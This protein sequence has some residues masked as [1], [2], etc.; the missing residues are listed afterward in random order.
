VAEAMMLHALGEGSLL[1]PP[2]VAV[3][4]AGAAALYVRGLG[5]TRQ[6]RPRAVAF[7]CGWSL[8]GIALATPLHGAGQ[9]WLSAHMLQHMLL[10]SLAAPLLVWSRPTGILLRGLPDPGRSV[11]IRTMGWLRPALRR[12]SG[13]G[14]A[15]ALQAVLLWLWHAPAFYTRTLTSGLVHDA[16][17]ITLL[18]G[19]VL[20][21][22][23]IEPAFRQRSLAG[24]AVLSLFITTLHTSVLAALL[25]FSSV[26]WYAPYAWSPE[27]L[28][29]QQLAG[30]IM[31]VPGALPYV[32]GALLVLW[33][34]LEE[35]RA[36]IT[37][38]T[39]GSGDGMPSPDAISRVRNA[40]PEA[41]PGRK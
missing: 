15:C 33:A 7:I 21:W 31:W 36:R 29:D 2:G 30:L 11:V 16:Q 25:T 20:F 41:A 26:V 28:S 18:G 19:A 1:P 27:A 38:T 9:S 22:A 6:K 5:R 14:V 3:P 13:I 23:S 35:P 10:M 4:L 34:V 17:H 12:L 8:L 32:A 40:A 24:P 37:A 39:A